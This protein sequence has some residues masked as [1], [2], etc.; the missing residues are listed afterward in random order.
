MTE[1]NFI[2]IT[3]GIGKITPK[4]GQLTLKDFSHNTKIYESYLM[5]IQWAKEM[6]EHRQSEIYEHKTGKNDEST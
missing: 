6:D 2:K 4:K 3:D 5:M 1:I